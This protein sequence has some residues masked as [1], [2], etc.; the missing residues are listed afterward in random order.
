MSFL[1]GG[2]TWGYVQTNLCTHLKFENGAYWNVGDSL[3]YLEANT[4]DCKLENVWIRGLGTAAVALTRSFYATGVRMTFDNC[5]TSNRFASAAFNGFEGTGTT[6]T[7]ITNKYIGCNANDLVTSGVNSFISG[8]YR[9]YNLNSC[10]SKSIKLAPGAGLAATAIGFY[11]CNNISSCTAY[12]IDSTDAG[13][14][15]AFGFSYSNMVSSGY[16]YTISGS[17]NSLGIGF[18][19]CSILSSCYANGVNNDGGALGSA[20]GFM[21]CDYLSACEALNITCAG[22]SERG[23]HTCT[24][25]SSLYTTEATNP[26]NDWMNTNDAQITNKY[27]VPAVF[28]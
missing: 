19:H 4:S 6:A 3:F 1:S 5:K 7:D 27:S 17:A 23:F 25:G 24:Y 16:A 26:S 15:E 13:T 28:T 11:Y 14:G 8:F 12:M 18:N 2:D 21:F 20:L 22:G 9:N 10:L